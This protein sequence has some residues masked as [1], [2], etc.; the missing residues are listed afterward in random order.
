MWHAVPLHRGGAGGFVVWPACAKLRKLVPVAQMVRR[1][2][3]GEMCSLLL[4]V[5]QEEEQK[6]QQSGV[7]LPSGA[8]SQACPSCCRAAVCYCWES[9]SNFRAVVFSKMGALHCTAGQ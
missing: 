4:L 9:L 1:G 3:M 8:A 7:G 5:A 2:G 6:E